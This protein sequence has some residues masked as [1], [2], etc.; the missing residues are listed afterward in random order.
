MSPPRSI[1]VARLVG[2]VAAFGFLGTAHPQTIPAFPGAE[3]AGAYAKGGRGGDVYHVTNT[4]ASGAGSLAYGLTTGVPGTGRTI[5]FD[6]SGYANIT[7]VNSSSSNVT[8]ITAS[9]ITIAGQTAPGDGFGLKNGTVLVSGDDIV[10][11]Y[12]RF[13][14]GNSADSIDLDSGSLNSIFDHCDAMLS[15]DEN[16][17]SFGSPP[18]NLTFQ[19]GMNAW[20]M[21]SH[22]CG[23][24]WDQNHA[25]CHH[26]L[27]AHNHT[28]N[29][30]ARPSLLDW[31]NNVTFDWD[32]G[33]ILADSDTPAN[34]NANVIGS[35]FIAGT[36]GKTKA[37]EKGAR[38]R[39]GAWNFH[40]YQNNNRFDGN[41][42]GLVDGTDTGWGM[43]S[44]DVEHLASALVNTGVPVT[45]DD[46][47]TAYKKIVSAAG[48]LRLDASSTRTLRDEIGA[49]LT[50]EL[51]A[52]THHHVSSPGGTGANN[53]GFGTLLSDPAPTDTDRDGMPDFWENALGLN[54]ALDDHNGVL[55]AAQLT[56]S[57]FPGGTASGYTW[58]EEYLH[59]L[60]IPHA[61]VAK[62]TTA[63][64]TSADFDLR[65]FTSG[66]SQS[67]VF[68]VANVSGGAV[69]QS[70]VGNTLAHFVPTTTAGGVPGRAKF[71]FTVTDADGST[72]TQQF[73]ILVSA[74]GIPRDL[75]WQGDGT[76][77]AWDTTANNWQWNGSAA[78]FSLGDTVLVN[79]LGSNTPSIA[80][81][82]T[83]SPGSVNV[84]ATKNYT[85]AGTG[86][87]AGG[88]PLTKSGTGTLTLSVA[89]G[90]GGGTTLNAGTLAIGNSGALGT[91]AVTLNGG[92]FSIGANA[93]VN[94]L[95]IANDTTITGGSGGGLT[96][97]GAV[98]G[99][100]SLTI[101]ATNV[102]DLR[103]DMSGF[104]GT[105]T[106]TGN[107][108]VR[109]NGS[110]GGAGATFDLGTGTNALVKRGTAATI[111]LGALAG[112]IG[113]ALSGATGTGNTT[114]TT[115]IIGDKGLSTTFAGTITNGAGTS[116]ITKNG[117]GTLTL[118]GASSYTGATSVSVGTLA[119]SGALGA[120]DVT[121]AG[122]AKLSVNGSIGGNVTVQSGGALSGAGGIFSGTVAVQSGATLSP[123]T[124]PGAAGTL[125]VNNGMSVAGA[126]LVFDLSGSPSGSNDTIVV[127]SGTIA[128]SGANVLQVNATDGVLGAGDYVL[129]SGAAGTLVTASP[130][131]ATPAYTPP[132]GIRQTFQVNRPSSGSGPANIVLHVINNA[133]SLTW[134]VA[135][136][137]WDLNSSASWS[138]GP[139]ATFFNL[140]AATFG[141]SGPG[142]TVNISSAV[143]PRLITVN[144]VSKD[145]A[146]VT[147]GAGN[148]GGSGRLEKDGA[149]ILSI[150]GG[151][152]FSGGTTI[153]GGGIV[154][155]D[156]AAN[157]S[158][159]GTGA[160]TFKGGT[161]TMAGFNGPNTVAYQWAP[162][163]NA[164]IVPAGQ[165]GTLQLT[166]RAP[167]PGPANVF[168]AI[169]G[170]L[171]GGGTLN[172][173][174]KFV[175]GDVLGDWSA[176]TGVLNIVP[177]DAD[178]GD[179]RFGTDGSWPGLP[180]ATVNL[181]ANMAA[182][183]VGTSNGG[184]GTTIEIGE[185]SGTASSYLA[186]GVTGGRNFTYRIGGRTPLGGEVTF[187]GTIAEQGVDS[188][189][190]VPS[191]SYVKTGA[192]T[193][194]LGG[195]CNW[196]G[197]TTVE[198]GTLKITGSVTCGAATN[199]AAGAS[200]S[201]AGGTISTD[202]VNIAAGAALTGAGSIRGDLNNSG[203]VTCG[204]GALAVTGEVV[205][206]GTMRFTGGAALS[207]GGHFVNNGVIDL[208]TGAQAL[209]VDFENN[210]VVIDSGSLAKVQVSKAG[211]VVTVTAQGYTQHTYQLQRADS[212][213]S[214][215]WSPIGTAQ[216][217]AANGQQLTFTDNAAT[218][219]QRFYRITVS[220]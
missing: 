19:W 169:Y 167:K 210:G 107:S 88:A 77:N 164:L 34:W 138:G 144:A 219:A 163:P 1:A 4:N 101:N 105:V 143:S 181:G 214:P 102:F 122:G 123:G 57:F 142:G 161:L 141:E 37:L 191:S 61:V 119:V 175:R 18:E 174:I 63:A 129:F 114:A 149:A 178:G 158:G 183:Y 15:N 187:A 78:A 185:L 150:T 44:G 66:F 151:N 25:T 98:S 182:Y 12:M 195:N 22:S 79:D 23:G 200:L 139:T 173:A 186:G 75:R 209:P 132:A 36:T 10:I 180:A 81:G 115:F 192:G 89:N 59:F 179:F 72:W 21:E 50:N 82:G 111:S 74:S 65:K 5:V 134:N 113:T 83:I 109:L 39:N 49:I 208:L 3:G 69:T 62:S 126:T 155:T 146:F 116:G 53:G 207:A 112:G 204:A 42:N 64:P 93:P 28:R 96:G 90:Y 6:V 145:Y 128:L 131:S 106:L 52:Q 205:N 140:D 120:T 157:T 220:P 147:A 84:D 92:T 91:G 35:Y 202:A 80:L 165:S 121:V 95:T 45:V 110:T 26:S 171:S 201:L 55:S 193:W 85:F 31:V 166:Q 188:Y 51:V 117:E 16:M 133:A 206:S 170:A 218:G 94:A 11:R 198:Q 68:T 2:C 38:D 103:G 108:S 125:T 13:R 118:A 71:T 99:A 159:L 197:G 135:G 168:P 20:G 32:I 17:S 127:N 213:V 40:V 58:L 67:P 152:S 216:V 33:F 87:I 60:A 148:I 47:L 54:P 100:A 48:P 184:A 217:P 14:D 176:F 86:S 177:V 194:T 46:P 29:P 43:V 162:M 8:R 30:K 73:G 76:A 172:L 196:N 211:N 136:G 130:S 124:A 154:L 215:S 190:N 199:V 70:G 104:T 203:I 9:K 27:W 156:S 137:T 153:L 160:I 97:I 41:R 56:A 7:K 189:G 24:L 212:L